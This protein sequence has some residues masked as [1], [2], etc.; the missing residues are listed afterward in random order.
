[1]KLE[2]Q[3]SSKKD[4]FLVT[5]DLTDKCNYRC[6]YCPE[7]LNN[8]TVG[9]PDFE[10]TKQFVDRLK[11]LLPNK[12]ICYR[13]SGGEPTTWKHFIDLVKYIK[14][15]N[16]YVSFLSNGS[17]KVSYYNEISDYTDGMI[18]SYHP[19]Y[20][21]VNHFIEISKVMKSPVAVNLMLLPEN[22][23]QTCDLAEH[24]Y[25]NTNLAIWPKIVLDKVHMSNQVISYTSEQLDY[26]KDWPYFRKLDDSKIHR[27]ELLLDGTIVSANDLILKGLNKHNGWTCYSGIDQINVSISGEIYR[28]DCQVG[29]SLGTIKDFTLPTEP[30]ICTKSECTCLSDIY[31]RKHD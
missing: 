27:G 30:Q 31:I 8:G 19:E 9:H 29:G 5:W 22:F 25:N 13:F 20:S 10:T 12:T 1:M 26:I 16:D 2:Y 24:L 3:D 6:S 11:E 28:A 4:W 17:R 23:K 21:D 18:L 7:Y 15:K 14:S